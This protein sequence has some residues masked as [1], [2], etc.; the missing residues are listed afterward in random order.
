MTTIQDDRKDSPTR[1][2]DLQ[3]NTWFVRENNDSRLFRKY[4]ADQAINEGTGG[5]VVVQAG[6]PCIPVEV[7]IHII[8]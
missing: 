8:S 5:I 7:A 4:N 6:V 2:E 3:N 1:F